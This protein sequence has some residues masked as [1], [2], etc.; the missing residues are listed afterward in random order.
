MRKDIFGVTIAGSKSEPAQPSNKPSQEYAK[1][2]CSDR[3]VQCVD[4]AAEACPHCGQ[5]YLPNAF[6]CRSCQMKRHLPEAGQI[7]LDK[8]PPSVL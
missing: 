2:L 4:K 8:M 3:S 6:F 7:Q 1:I 5:V